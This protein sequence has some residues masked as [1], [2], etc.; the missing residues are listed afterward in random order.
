MINFQ[1]KMLERVLQG[2]ETSLDN[3]TNLNYADKGHKVDYNDPRRREEV[4]RHTRAA[5]RRMS[6]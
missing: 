6:W 5:L 3:I 1:L 2:V 4:D